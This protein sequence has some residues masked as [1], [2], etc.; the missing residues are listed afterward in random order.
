MNTRRDFVRG[1]SGLGA[2]IATGQ[3]PAAIVRSMVAVRGAMFS[4]GAKLSAKSYVQDG[5]VAMWDG[6]E[7]AGWGVHDA[8]ATTWADLTG[9]GYNLTVG[10]QSSFTTNSLLYSSVVAKGAA[11]R[12]STIGGVLQ[13]EICCDITS[14]AGSGIIVC[15]GPAHWDYPNNIVVTSNN[16]RGVQTSYTKRHEAYVRQTGIYR[17]SCTKDILYADGKQVIDTGFNSADWASGMSQF[18]LFGRDDINYWSLGSIYSVRLYNRELTA[19]EVA[20]NDTVDVARF[21]LAS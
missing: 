21:N 3:A 12:N 8:A 16:T 14:K 10:T 18:S 17:I 6:I 5:L 7:N 9:N 2:I 13:C 1:L 19:D 11:Y 4:G 20:L 15:N